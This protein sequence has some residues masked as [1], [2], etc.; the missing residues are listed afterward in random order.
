MKKIY[1]ICS[2]LAVLAVACKEKSNEEMREADQIDSQAL[3]NGQ[4]VAEKDCPNEENLL[5]QGDTFASYTEDIMRGK[6]VISFTME[7][8]D[9]LDFLNND[10]SVFG[11]IVLNEDLTFFTLKMPQKVIAR[12]VIPAYDFAA[13]DFDCEDIGTDPDYFIIYIN[14]EKRKI[15]KDGL[16]YTFSTWEDYIKKQHIGLKSCNLIKDKEGAINQKSSNQAFVVSKINE[17]EIEITSDKN[18][19]GEDVPFESVKGKVKW[20]SGNKLLINFALCN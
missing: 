6:G 1:F 9:R 18:C 8:N 10:D 13:F 20:K 16:K 15:K 12:K 7:I 11:E 14:K 17:D 5:W 4:Q 19:L 3:A 2:L